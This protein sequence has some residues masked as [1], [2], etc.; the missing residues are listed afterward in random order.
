M[1]GIIGAYRSTSASWMQ[2]QKGILMTNAAIE[3]PPRSGNRTVFTIFCYDKHGIEKR[4][5]L[6]TDN[7]IVKCAGAAL[8]IWLLLSFGGDELAKRE[9]REKVDSLRPTME[10][11]ANQG[12]DEA[13]LWKA[14]HYWQTNKQRVTALAAK[15]VPE[16]MLM[17][18]AVQ[19]QNGDKEGGV[20]WIEK[21]AAAG[22]ADA[23]AYIA[24][25]HKR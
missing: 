8:A 22:N 24:R 3:S 15:G 14:K 18:G 20:H 2:G 16:A 10:A 12:Q 1:I 6:V 17:Q 23:I 19:I 11:L 4:K 13:S 7:G 9:K 25:E 21:S 5:F